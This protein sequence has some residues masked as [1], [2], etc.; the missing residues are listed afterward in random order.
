MGNNIEPSVRTNMHPDRLAHAARFGYLFP[1]EWPIKRCVICGKMRRPG[2][3]REI[4]RLS[5]EGFKEG[6]EI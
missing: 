3:D 1:F 6:K 2:T 5:V 4:E